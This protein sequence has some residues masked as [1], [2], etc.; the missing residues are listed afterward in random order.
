M[1]WHMHVLS[2]VAELTPAPRLLVL[3]LLSSLL[4]SFAR[5]GASPE[6]KMS[7]ELL[8]VTDSCSSWN[9][10]QWQRIC[11]SPMLAWCG[12]CAPHAPPG[13]G[14]SLGYAVWGQSLR[15]V[16]KGEG[17]VRGLGFWAALLVPDKCLQ[18][19]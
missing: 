13:F 5:L 15:G 8:W 16:D 19:W 11:P 3:P 4:F 17:A 9:L 6:Q 10:F 2:A 7:L 1:S 18:R 14:V 12:M